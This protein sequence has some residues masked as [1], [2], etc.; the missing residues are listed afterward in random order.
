MDEK[1]SKIAWLWT[2]NTL[3]RSN[4]Q[5]KIVLQR[6]QA[7]PA[8]FPKPPPNRGKAVYPVKISVVPLANS[9][10][11]GAYRNVMKSL[12]ESSQMCMHYYRTLNPSE[13]DKHDRRF[14]SKYLNPS[15]SIGIQ[16]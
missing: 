4:K 2:S 10:L 3:E 11:Q 14:C 1:N 5:A 16:Q 7:R 9:E 15:S 8:A 13:Y 12:S 6:A